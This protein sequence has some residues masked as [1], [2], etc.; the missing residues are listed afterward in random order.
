MDA[1]VP[2]RTNFHRVDEAM[3]ESRQEE[4]WI[5]ALFR[6]HPA[7]LVS[8][9]Y[10]AAS[11]IGM[12]FSWDYLRLFGINVFNYAQIGDFLLASLKE[13]ITWIIVFVS[14]LLT[15]GDNAMSRRVGRSGKR[16]FLKWY[17][18]DRYRMINS[19]GTVVVIVM[20]THLYVLHKKDEVL[21]GEGRLVNV[22]LTESVVTS[23]VVLLGTTGSFIFLYDP[24]L[25][26]VTVHPHENVYSI[27]FD[28][29]EQ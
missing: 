19:I 27:S 4:R 11:V 13:P 2:Q 12:L 7:L 8:A 10:V 1:H 20:F 29:E 18:S 24:L 3:V 16:R 15:M 21:A 17:G 5:L 6:Q 22:Q 23:R 9:V 25:K 26:Q 14:V 28:L